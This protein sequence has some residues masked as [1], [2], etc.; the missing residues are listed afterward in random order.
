MLP[1]WYTSESDSAKPAEYGIA[2]RAVG[3]GHAAINEGGNGERS[4]IGEIDDRLNGHPILLDK[5]GA[6]EDEAQAIRGRTPRNC[7]R[8]VGRLEDVPENEI[9]RLARWT[10]DGEENAETAW[11][12]KVKRRP[13][14][15]AVSAALISARRTR[16][17]SKE[18][19]LALSGPSRPNSTQ[20]PRSGPARRRLQMKALHAA[21]SCARCAG[22]ANHQNR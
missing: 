5:V 20:R 19:S 3:P 17:F 14:A 21:A 1:G 10:H 22:S 11:L 13:E 15:S 9:P 8:A 6:D 2:G 16:Y 18:R 4:L 12:R 7:P